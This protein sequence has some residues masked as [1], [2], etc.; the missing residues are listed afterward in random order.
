MTERGRE[1]AN[2]ME[3]RWKGNKA[4]D[5]GAWYK[6]FYSECKERGRNGV[7]II[8]TG[9]LKSCVLETG[10]PE[11]EKDDFWRRLDQEMINIPNEELLMIGGDLNG[12]IGRNRQVLERIHGGWA[13][14]DQNQDGERAMDFAVAFDMAV[15][16]TFFE[17]LPKY[18]TT[19]KSGGQESQINFLLGRRVN[20]KEIRNC[21]IF[22]GE[23]VTPQH[24]LL[25]VDWDR[26]R[27]IRGKQE[28]MPKIR[29]WKLKEPEYKDTFI[30]RIL[31]E[32][33]TWDYEDVDEWWERKSSILKRV[34]REVLG[35]STGK[36]T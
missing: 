24:R 21:K 26:K 18:L 27:T 19:Y 32:L 17:T 23:A 36:W 31:V 34:G 14:G 30:E 33:G 2:I 28:M 20:L 16:N 13:L 25:T 35:M 11:E 4:R 29:W 1:V 5:I 9:K 8:L 6:L 7:G 10:R 15:I 3:T 22:P 12:H